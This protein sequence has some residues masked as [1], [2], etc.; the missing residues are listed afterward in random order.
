MNSYRDIYDALASLC[1][2]HDLPR[3]FSLDQPEDA[4]HGDYATNIAFPLAKVLG[5][6]PKDTAETVIDDLRGSLSEVVEKIE[7][8]GPGFINFFLLDDVRTDEAEGVAVSDIAN[9]TGK[10]R[11][12]VEYTDPNC[13]KV[14][15]VGH[16]MA[17]TIGEATA[18]LYEAS[19]YD[20]TRVCYPSD[21]GRN[22]AMGVWGVMKKESEKP[23]SGATLKEKIEFLGAC[24]AYANNAFETDEKA[25]AEIVEVNKAIYDGSD[26]RV[27]EVY[28]EGR[29]LSL[30]YFDTLYGK[31][32]TTFD[33]FIYESEVADPGLAIVKANMGA[34]F[35]ES[36]GAIVFKGESEGLHTRV[37][38]N[39]V[40]LPTYETKDLGNYE[41]KLALVP[42]AHAYVTITAAEQN[43]YFKVVNKVEEKIYP[44][45]AG[46]LVHISH[47]MMRLPSG[48]MSSRTGNVI[49][50]EDL[51]DQITEKI[52]ERIKE[53]RVEA[54]DQAQLANDIAVGAVKFSILKQAPGKDTIFDFD[55]S[56]SFEGD[57]GPYL[58][59]THARLCALLD[60]ASEAGIDIES[61]TIENPERELEQVI[62]GY[63]QTLEKAYADLGPHHIVQ[64]LLRLT[65][66]FNN[67]YGRQ[68][69]VD[70]NEK[71]KSAYYV[72]LSQ[73]VKNILAHG[74]HTLGISAPERM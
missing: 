20:V 55:K 71:E 4:L 13:F 14:F 57:S 65:R 18:R 69:I 37:F 52:G 42:H 70:E 31:L 38:V 10:G 63:T 19:G 64:H 72:M 2:K 32:G 45:L 47:G 6:S 33:A 29:A 36:E 68:Q 58:Q 28:A 49:G 26:A 56:I 17:N 43:D 40:G 9:E 16:L 11:V 12:L 50:G 1:Q 41:K 25:K 27:M 23:S 62:I 21:I 73:A 67:M 22:V 60:K 61:Y 48:K 3:A 39:S 66:A 15:H 54:K 51:L 8:A 7:V 74:L 59:Y 34:I 24:Y 5:K 53:M 44:E 30:E 46:K 35:E